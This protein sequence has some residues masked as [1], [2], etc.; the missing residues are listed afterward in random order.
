MSR[1]GLH[2]LFT[3]RTASIFLLG[4][5]I[6]ASMLCAG[7]QE[8]LDQVKILVREPLSELL[9]EYQQL[10]HQPLQQLRETVELF[11]HASSQE[12]LYQELARLAPD[13]NPGLQRKLGTLWR[14][15]TS[16]VQEELNDLHLDPALRE[17][18]EQLLQK[19]EFCHD[20][21]QLLCRQT[22]LQR[23]GSYAQKDEHALRSELRKL[24]A[25]REKELRDSEQRV[26]LLILLKVLP[27][28]D[29]QDRRV[30]EERL[31]SYGRPSS[32]I[33]EDMGLQSGFLEK[34]LPEVAGLIG[35]AHDKEWHPEGDVF[36]HTMLVLD[37]AA[38]EECDSNWERLALLYAAM[39][40]DLG[41]KVTTTFFPDAERRADGTIKW[42]VGSRFHDREGEP[43]ARLMMERI[44]AEPE[45]VEAVAKLTRW[46]MEHGPLGQ[47][48]PRFSEEI[49]EQKCRELREDIDGKIAFTT[50]LKLMRAD[51]RGSGT[52]NGRPRPEREF[53]LIERYKGVA[54]DYG[55]LQDGQGLLDAAD[56]AGSDGDQIYVSKRRHRKRKVRCESTVRDNELQD[57]VHLSGS[58]QLPE[59]KNSGND[60]VP[61]VKRRRR[62]VAV[63]DVA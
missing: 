57:D 10:A 37:A 18:I 7:G 26:K 5:I 41:K 17:G 25:Q 20:A 21:A 61:K 35:L 22:T 30:F 8:I 6:C 58:S 54:R 32:L 47:E 63:A 16:A 60:V 13:L 27:R 2:Q 43:I 39:T 59:E 36:E 55:L 9:A 45:L 53:D 3:M 15:S 56:D 44:G 29:A 12:G 1:L 46:H 34:M 4:I 51:M 31:Q 40:H 24:L 14:K 19:R 33:R 52:T 49:I 50:L 38:E 28:W 48:M 42:R 23:I 11:S 62:L